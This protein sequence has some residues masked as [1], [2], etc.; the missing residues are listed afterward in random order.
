[1]LSAGIVFVLAV[2]ALAYIYAGYPLILRLIV[3]LRGPRQVRQQ[4]I[5]PRVSLVIS[6]FNEAR[7]IREKL[8]NALEIDYPAELL[9]IAVISDA[10]D[11]GT[12]EIV[13]EYAPRGVRLFRQDERRGKTAGLNRFVP[14]LHGDIIVFSD[15]NAMY[16]RAALRML[17][18]NFAD[19]AVGYV[20]GEARYLAGE[21]TA[22][23]FGER[24]YW[25][26]EILIKRLETAVGSMVGGDGAIYAIR[27]QLWRPLPD[28]AINDFLNPLQIVEA[29][30][31]GVYEPAAV[32]YE[33]TAGDARREYRRRVRIV[34][35]SWR[36]VFQAP[37]VLNPFRAGLFT[38]CLISHKL[39]RWMTGV[40]VA[41]AA[42]AL[43][44]LLLDLFA[45]APRRV[46]ASVAGLVLL[47]VLWAP[48]RRI[49]SA[50][51]YYVVISL[52]SVVGIIKGTTGRVSGVW[53][54]PRAEDGTRPQPAVHFGPGM[55]ALGAVA[56]ATG[57]AVVALLSPGAAH[58][59][60]GVFWGSVG[61]LAYVYAGYPLLL[62]VLRRFLRRPIL[63]GEIEP[64]VSLFIAANDEASVIEAKLRNS[65]ELEYPSSRLSIVVAS[66]GSVDG[67]NEIVRGFE[68]RGVRLIESDT[69]RGKMAA[70]NEGMRSVSSDVVVFSDANTFLDAGAV[71]AL[72]RNFADETVGA[73]SGDVV[74]V[75][76]RAALGKSEDLYYRYERWLQQAESDLGSMLGV[77]GALY[78]IRRS[79]FEPPPADTILDDMAIPMAVVRAGRRVVF[80]PRAV[81]YEQGSESATEEFARKARVVA[82][83]VQFL[84]R[85][86]SSV[87]SSRFQ[88]LA[89][90][91]SHKTL[92]WLSPLFAALTFCASLLLAADSPVFT[93]AALLQVV[94]LAGGLLGCVP[95]L[96]RVSPFGLAHYFWLVQAA[97]AVGFVRGMLG[98]QSV[99]W[100]RF[101][102]APLGVAQ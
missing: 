19:P 18:R 11:D 63:N 43:L 46:A 84:L 4:P 59:H 24:V 2:A 53:T 51:V 70:I 50:A 94:F 101:Q 57:L 78:A 40:F 29:G 76:D 23:S 93:L 83:A 96:R 1:M 68:S 28:D 45:I 99:A 97:A 17:V 60:R 32:A 7:S 61:A 75:G 72:V 33:Q 71:K 64:S 30:W 90:L 16:D 77:D 13:R 67:T 27:R 58:W 74:L 20:T 6:A 5:L 41:A 92:R 36:A 98:R 95:A 62:A 91:I 69:R 102:R 89:A 42:G 80:E 25:D 44:A 22:A 47:A 31:R 52:A 54:P 73:V 37:G 85:R 12:D 35:R 79:L 56:V 65:L 8:R 10:S 86:D 14:G 88:V 49:V 9:D 15:A 39:L 48:A 82:G 81:A 34:S 26:Y 100:R 21:A 87:P 3:W 38:F 66:D 55:L